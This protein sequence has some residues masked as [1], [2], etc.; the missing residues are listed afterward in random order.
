MLKDQISVGDIVKFERHS[1]PV[2]IVTV[3][4][5][6]VHAQNVVNNRMM[7]FDVD[8]DSKFVVWS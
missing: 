2:R 4:N 6:G 5:N 8:S 7:S 1:N 3:F